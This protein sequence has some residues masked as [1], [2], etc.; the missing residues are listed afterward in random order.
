MLKEEPHLAYRD[1]K[2]IITQFAMRELYQ[3]TLGETNFTT[4][5]DAVHLLMRHRSYLDMHFKVYRYFNERNIRHYPFSF[6][7]LAR[8]VMKTIPF[9]ASNIVPAASK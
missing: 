6:G 5:Y 1:K 2:R 4:K 7:D 3:E 9:L 8:D